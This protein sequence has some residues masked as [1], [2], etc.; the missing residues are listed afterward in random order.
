VTGPR[1]LLALRALGLGDALTG[2]PALRGLRRLVAPAPLV[3]AAPG[4]I[5]RWMVEM[6]VVDGYVETPD[7]DAPPPGRVLGPHDAVD[8]HGNGRP[9]RDLLQRGGATCITDFALG[10]P[11]WCTDEHEVDRW[12]RLARSMGASCGRED[13]RLRPRPLSAS[14]DYVVVHAGAASGSRRW[15]AGRWAAVIQALAADGWRVVLTGAATERGLCEQVRTLSGVGACCDT[16]GRLSL[17][18]LADVVGGAA[19]VLCGDTGVA[20]LAT[21][22][23]VPSV[24]LFGPVSPAAWGPAIDPDL[25]RV[26]WHGDG[27]GDPH[28]T[29][30]DPHLLEV[31]VPEVVAEARALLNLQDDNERLSRRRT[32]SSPAASEG[33]GTM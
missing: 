30:P 5:G 31:Q 2:V 26:I 3:L 12:C 17:P 8:L 15:P 20:H 4:V 10:G 24:L 6:D 13:L 33:P 14:G 16:A 9:S 21:A 18:A 19:L 23:A 7:L 28:G 32:R 11:P 1:P 22:L 25:H 27:H 29:T